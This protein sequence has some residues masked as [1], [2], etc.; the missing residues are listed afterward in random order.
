MEKRGLKRV[1]I[2][3]TPAAAAFEAAA[4]TYADSMRAEWVPPDI[5]DQ[6]VRER[7]AYRKQRAATK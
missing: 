6:A 1:A 3:G 7:D 5:F 2:K 4:K